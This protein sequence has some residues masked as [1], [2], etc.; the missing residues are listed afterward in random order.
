[1]NTKLIYLF[2]ILLSLTIIACSSDNEEKVIDDAELGFIKADVESE[3]TNL[4]TKAKYLDNLPGTS[5]KLK[6]A[7]ENAP[8]MIP[9]TVEGFLPIKAKNNIC[10][11]CHL[12]EKAKEVNSVPLPK[13]HFTE[14]RP[15]LVKKG[16]VYEMAPA[17]KL[18]KADMEH[19][20]YSYF[21][22]TQC[23]APQARITVNIENLFTPEF[24]SKLSA[25]KSDLN[26]R[27]DEGVK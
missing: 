11:S 25:N 23:H 14:L 12:P 16:G 21:N 10:L 22:C 15:E 13:T 1:M 3:Q 9:H 2:I 19:F 17:E 27:I 20:N 7:F 18:F 24:R 26:E 6:R 8:P 4:K 5:I